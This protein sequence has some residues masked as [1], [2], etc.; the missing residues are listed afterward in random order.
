M[1]VVPKIIEAAGRTVPL[2][3]PIVF[4]LVAYYEPSAH[5]QFTRRVRNNA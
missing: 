4:D 5:F 2:K 1:T 3:R